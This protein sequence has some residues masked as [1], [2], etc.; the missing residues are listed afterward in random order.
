MGV[1]PDVFATLGEE[2]SLRRVIRIIV[3]SGLMYSAG[4]VLFFVVYVAGNNALYGVSD[5]VSSF[6]TRIS[7]SRHNTNILCGAGRAD[8][9]RSCEYNYYSFEP[10]FFH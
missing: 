3:E 10:D 5:C 1:F 7:K 8:Y 2:S 9:C 6:L 4:V